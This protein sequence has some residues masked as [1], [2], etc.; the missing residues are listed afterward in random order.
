MSL[1]VRNTAYISKKGGGGLKYQQPVLHRE[2]RVEIDSENGFRII[3]EKGNWYL[4]PLVYKFME[5]K[6]IRSEK[7][8]DDILPDILERASFKSEKEGKDLTKCLIE[9]LEGVIPELGYE[10]NRL[11]SPPSSHW[12]LFTPPTTSPVITQHLMCDYE[13]LTKQLESDPDRIGGLR[14]LEDLPAEDI[15]G[16]IDILPIIPLN[17]SQHEAVAD[18]I[19]SKPVTVISGPPGCGKSQVVISLLLNAWAKGTSVLFASNNNKAVDV[20]HERFE[21]FESDFP[22]AVRAGT[23]KVSNIE[24]TLRRILNAMVGAKLRGRDKRDT[25]AAE[26]YEKLSGERKYLQDLLEDKI[27]QRVNEALRSALQAY[28][29]YQEEVRKLNDAHELLVKEVRG[30]GYAIDPYEFEAMITNPLHDWLE[31]IKESRIRIEQDSHNRSNFTNRAATSAD[32]RNRAVQQ[33]GLD[34]NVVTNWNWL[35]SGP[36]PELIES[37]LESYKLFLSPPIEQRLAPIDWQGVFGDWKGEGDA[38]NWSQSGRQLAKDIR[39]TCDE[40][41]SKVAEIEDMKKRF[42][43]QYHAIQEAGIPDDIHVDPDILSEWVAVYATVYSLHEGKFDWCPWSQ[44]RKLVRKLQSIEVRIRPAYP[45]SVWR[46]IGEINETSRETLG[47]II[48][49]TRKWIAIRNQWDE[50]KTMRQEIDNRLEALRERATELHIDDIPD[51][52]DLSAWL[53]LAETIEEKTVVADAAADAWAKKAT[54]EETRERLRELAIEFQSAASGVPIKEAWTSGLGHEFTQ[55]VLALGANPT[56]DDVV[57]AR[58]SLYGESIVA[59]LRA[60]HEARDAEQEF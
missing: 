9:E 19:R 31:K 45:L 7:P 24:E 15:D 36:G 47:G 51:G 13:D 22:I 56:Q 34:S 5:Q 18:A 25:T 20:V 52:F 41:S 26:R 4:S 3:P 46:E 50:K 10:L 16:E 57:S 27:P 58:T 42:D 23:R 48:E 29:Q 6:R 30:L 38:H 17:N 60:W 12:V 33:V 21:H 28:G 49:L 39:R 44:R 55:S 1:L 2:V 14:L 40:L 59:L 11:K 43:G 35:I 37:W 8:L 32:A 53:K 54:A